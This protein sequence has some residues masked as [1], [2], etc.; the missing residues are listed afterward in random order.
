MS[1]GL[2]T[3]LGETLDDRAH[4]LPHP[5]RIAPYPG[6]SKAPVPQHPRDDRAVFVLL[7]AC[8]GGQRRPGRRPADAGECVDGVYGWEL[9]WGGALRCDGMSIC[10]I[11]SRSP[12]RA[13]MAY[14][15]IGHRTYA[16]G[17]ANRAHGEF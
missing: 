5:L 15:L 3:T 12:L 11:K 14:G 9:R 13:H 6:R 10:L 8:A 17:S 2:F 1:I 16:H 7:L 4:R